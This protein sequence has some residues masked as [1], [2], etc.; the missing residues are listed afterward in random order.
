[1]QFLKDRTRT[2]TELATSQVN[3]HQ[4]SQMP[5][6]VQTPIPVRD[7]EKKCTTSGGSVVID[8]QM[9]GR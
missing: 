3:H 1:M 8:S 7:V 5:T 6:T 9:W 4:A 2:H